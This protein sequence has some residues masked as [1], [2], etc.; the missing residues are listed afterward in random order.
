MPNVNYVT[1][2]P[3][4]GMPNVN[5]ITT[6]PSAMS[7]PTTPFAT[8][9]APTHPQLVSVQQQ[10]MVRSPSS[11]A[12]P[13]GYSPYG[14]V[15]TPSGVGLSPVAQML[16]QQQAQEQQI[17]QEKEMEQRRIA[18]EME[19]QRKMKDI[20]LLKQQHEQELARAQQQ[21]KEQ[22]RIQEEIA[23]RDHKQRLN[24]IQQLQR[25]ASS[26]SIP[27]VSHAQTLAPAQSS[28][29]LRPASSSA[30]PSAAIATAP[31]GHAPSSQININ[32]IRPSSAHGT[33]PHALPAHMLQVLLVISAINISVLPYHSIGDSAEFRLIIC[34]CSTHI[35]S[36][37]SNSIGW[38]GS[39]CSFK[40]SRC[41][42]CAKG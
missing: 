14:G 2:G 23:E 40:Y 37:H 22:R 33:D 30:I 13:V 8:M 42:E 35:D 29:M 4:S 5:Y 31:A 25:P 34:S 21:E 3:Q 27:G 11:G 20:E 39:R 9:P 32:M 24:L 10:N 26:S 38:R 7:N 1:T 17:Q 19:H 12:L 18:Q 36:F 28:Q 41:I 15:G 16:L 6:S